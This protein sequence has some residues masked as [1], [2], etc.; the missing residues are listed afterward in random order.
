M[1][2][3]RFESSVGDP[4]LYIWNLCS[5]LKNRADKLTRGEAVNTLLNDTVWWCGSA[6]LKCS[7][8]EWPQ[9]EFE[10]INDDEKLEWR[11]TCVHAIVPVTLQKG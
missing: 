4:K 5:G 11:N 1:E 3:V 6:W 10:T 8:S 7:K 9:Q 2:T